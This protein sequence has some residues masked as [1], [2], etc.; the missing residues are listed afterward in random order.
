MVA[1]ITLH[2]QPK[3]PVIYDGKEGVYKSV[4][5]RQVKFSGSPLHMEN[6][7]NNQKSSLSG[8]TQGIWKFDQ[9]TGNFVC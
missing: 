3:G 7:K 6:R 9:N 5:G 1:G 2:Q 8:K 4:V